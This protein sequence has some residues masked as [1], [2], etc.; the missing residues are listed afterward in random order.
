MADSSK[1]IQLRELKDMIHDLQKMIKTL[2]ATVDAANKREEALTQKRDNLKE[3]VDLLRKKLFGTSSEKRVLD[4]PGQLN[5]F[6]EAELEQDPALAQVEELEASSSEK[7]PKKRKARATDAERFK[8][9]PVEKEYLDL[10]EKEKNCPVCGTALKQIGEEFVRRELVFIPARLKVREYYSRNYECPQ[11]S[12]H[13]IPVIKKGKD[14]RPHTLYGMACAG[15]VAWVMYQKFCNA[16]PYFRQEKDWKQYGASITRKTMAN[17]VIQNSEAFFLPM[18][19]YFQRK[20]LERKFAM[21]D[22]TPLQVLHE[23][24]RRAQTQS[25]MWLFRSGEDGLPPIILYKYSETRAGENAVDFLRGF[26][27]YLM[28]DGYSG[29]NKVPDA[30]RTACWAHIRRYLTDAIPKGKALDYTQPS[31]QGVMYIN[32]LFH[33]EDI[34]KAKHTSFDAI[35][36]AR[37]EKEK[38]V[39]EGFLSWLD[40]QAPV[41]G[42]RMD[43]AVTYIQNRRSYLT[44]YLEDGRCSFSNNLSENAIRP[45]TVG[46]KN[47]LFCDTP[48]GAQASAL[49]YSM[50]EIAKANGVNVYHYLTYLLEKMPSNRMSDEELELLAPWNENVKTEIQHRVNNTDQSDVNCQGTPATEK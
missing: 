16:L 8:G 31:V 13:G 42:S 34:I 24:G 45:F 22:E 36:K 23:P 38:P 21:A 43:K 40:Q 17:W 26:K 9:I 46:R 1:D 14:G 18:Y 39:V 32:Q 20:L 7:T 10:S 48:N 12:Q 28:C 19:E 30:K 29:Y 41:R 11:C 49:V 3:E 27:G 25:Y 33:L 35:K 50:V 15:T 4:I 5:F 2:Q 44:T 47:W 6:N 37:L